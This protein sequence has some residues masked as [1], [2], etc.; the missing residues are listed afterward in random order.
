LDLVY[1]N[2]KHDVFAMIRQVGAIRIVLFENKEIAYK[3]HNIDTFKLD[4]IMSKDGRINAAIYHI[5]PP[6]D[7]NLKKHFGD[8]LY[9]SPPP[10][11]DKRKAATER[12]TGCDTPQYEKMDC[13]TGPSQ[14]KLRF[15]DGKTYY[16]YENKQMPY[17][18]RRSTKR[19]KWQ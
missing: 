4:A 16:Y 7:N 2:N 11:S 6:N 18:F 15:A 8:E 3:M 9:Y 14:I 10:K 13:D 1:K 12:P 17:T 5:P 19:M